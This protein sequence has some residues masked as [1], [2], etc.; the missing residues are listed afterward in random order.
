MDKVVTVHIPTEVDVSPGK[1]VIWEVCGVQ[2]VPSCKLWC[3]GLIAPTGAMHCWNRVWNCRTSLTWGDNKNNKKISVS[4]FES[5]RSPFV[6]NLSISLTP[7]CE[8]SCLNHRSVYSLSVVIAAFQHFQHY[9][10]E[11]DMVTKLIWNV[12]DFLNPWNIWKVKKPHY[13]TWF[14]SRLLYNVLNDFILFYCHN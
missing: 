10:V 4:C 5:L 9:C 6:A 1:I 14:K 2:Q 7:H 12:G 8:C 13:F 11:G 3:L